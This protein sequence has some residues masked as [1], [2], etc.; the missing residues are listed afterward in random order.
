[1]GGMTDAYENKKIDYE[2]RGQS[3]GTANASAAAGT[4]PAT[5]YVALKLASDT[6]GTPGTEVSG[7]NYARVPVTC[8]LANWAGTQSAGSTT[9]SSGSSATTSNNI[10]V[11]FPTPGTTGTAWGQVIGFGLYDSLTGGTECWYGALGQAKTIN[12]GDPGPSFAPGS[13]VIQL[14]A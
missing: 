4:G 12:L 10:T 2:F 7:T 8:S 13:L 1:M 14:D 9:A 3:Y 6:D 11:T 5:W